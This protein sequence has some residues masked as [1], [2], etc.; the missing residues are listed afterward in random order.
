M[1]LIIGNKKTSSWSLRPW[2]LMR[3]FNISFDETLVKL[4]QPN[5]A[6]ELA[7][8]SPSSKVPVLIDGNVIIWESMA[9]FEFLNEKYPDK[10]LWPD[11]A[12]QRAHARAISCEMHAGF[13]KMRELMS[14]DLQNH[15]PDFD[16]T[17]AKSD[18]DRVSAIWTDCLEKY[19]GPFLFGPF[20]IADAMYAPVV[21][22]FVT[23]DVKCD[24]TIFN[25]IKTIRALPAHQEWIEAGLIESF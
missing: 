7:K 13:Q 5:S 18:V 10:K 24:T 25:Y 15:Y 11:K 21:N 6:I 16:Y 23:Y 14:H 17:A 8:V 2:L 9:I 1:R 19:G 3:Y 20:S 12:I 22:R 4:Y